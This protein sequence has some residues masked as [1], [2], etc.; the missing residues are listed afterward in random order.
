MGRPID[1]LV[2][3]RI[4]EDDVWALPAKF[5]SDVLQVAL[6]GSLHDL[7][8]CEGRT[9]EGDFLDTGMLGDRLTD[10]IPISNHE[11][12]DARGEASFTNHLGHHESGQGGKLGRLHND[13][14]PRG[15]SGTDL[16][17]PHQNY[18]THIRRVAEKSP[19]EW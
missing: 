14:V 18:E 8:T 3:I 5:E 16:P 13:G 1:R 4:V 10:R 19:R 17:A 2:N 15:Q 11:V 9:G 7:P 6:G 12:E